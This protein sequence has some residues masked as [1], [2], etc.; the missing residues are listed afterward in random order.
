MFIFVNQPG[1]PNS[2]INQLNPM[3]K[4][5][6]KLVASEQRGFLGFIFK[7][8][9]PIVTTALSCELEYGTRLIAWFQFASNCFI[10]LMHI[11]FLMY[12]DENCEWN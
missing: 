7:L 4:D 1:Q 12:K 6:L 10:A 8:K 2:A 5:E 9:V 3:S 11:M